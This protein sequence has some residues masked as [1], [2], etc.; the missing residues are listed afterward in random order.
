[1]DPSL[2][3]VN[4]LDY[5]HFGSWATEDVNFSSPSRNI[6]CGILGDDEY[7]PY[8]WGCAIG[9]K[10]WTFPNDS[11][12]D[13]CYDAVVPCGGGI[14]ASGTDLPH[15]RY[16]GD[17]GFPGAMVVGMPEVPV[18]V[19]EYG[20]SVTFNDVTCY[21]EE[22]G[23]TCEHAVSGHGFVIAKDRNDIY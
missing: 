17:P 12:E 10:E 9:D 18:R 21:S 4:D 13:Y 15:P 8:L 14:E 20:Q 16:R 22:I 3:F 11:P 2:F 7:T 23:I 5:V 19:L 1:M 6:G